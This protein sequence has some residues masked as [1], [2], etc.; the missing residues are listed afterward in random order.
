VKF[1]LKVALQGALLVVSSLFAGLVL[2]KMWR[3][4]IVPKFTSAPELDYLSAVGVNLTVSFFLAG[5]LMHMPTDKDDKADP[6]TKSIAQSA[7]S[8]AMILFFYP[9]LLFIAYLWHQFI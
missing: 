3:W 4:F 7:Q 6:L 8:A 1:F 5:V 2:S 9:F